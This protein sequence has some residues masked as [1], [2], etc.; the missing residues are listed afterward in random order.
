LSAI[1][2]SV[3]VR[4]D[5]HVTARRSTD[6]LTLTKP[7]SWIGLDADLIRIF[8]RWMNDRDRAWRQDEVSSLGRL[9]H[10]CLFADPALWEFVR[11]AINANAGEVTRLR[12]AFPSQGAYARYSTRP[13]EFAYRPDSHSFDGFLAGSK[14]L[15]LS[16]YIMNQE[17]PVIPKER[18]NILIL[19]SQPVDMAPVRHEDVIAAIKAAAAAKALTVV[20]PDYTKP[21]AA[22]V[23]EWLD[24]LDEPPDLI[25]FM[26]HGKYDVAS[27]TASMALCDKNGQADWVDDHTFAS[28]LTRENV[29]SAVVMH[30]CDAGVGDFELGFAG[31][32]PQLV[33]Q[34]VP[35]VVAMQYPLK[36]ST[37]TEFSIE[38]YEQ[39]ARGK[40][41]DEA[42]QAARWRISASPQSRSPRLLGLPV[43]YA[44]TDTPL[45]LATT[46]DQVA[47]T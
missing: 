2:V 43:V 34:G 7:G 44:Q 6:Q 22:D 21:T 33:L 8:E 10:R 38:L 24:R 26:G 15:V 47:H 17:S 23:L 3:I 12:L 32:A 35:F 25:H 41:L 40:P 5:G 16:R 13:W 11:T 14:N 19:V 9:L 29:P 45:L 28:I 1:S 20:D 46:A 36:N 4:D 31:V 42:A 18:L 30:S 37:A 27:G 39:L